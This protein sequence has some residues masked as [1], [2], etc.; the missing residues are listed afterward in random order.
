TPELF[1]KIG[2]AIS[3]KNLDEARIFVHSLKGSAANVGAEKLSNQA[4]KFEMKIKE[5][6]SFNF[7]DEIDQLISLFKELLNELK[8]QQLV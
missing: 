4:R 7:K 1:E 5:G 8:K 3:D 6:R 2:R